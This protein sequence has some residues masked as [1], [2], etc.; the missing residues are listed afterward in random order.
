MIFKV[1][2]YGRA[3]SATVK[4]KATARPLQRLC[5]AIAMVS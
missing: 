5:I 4:D 2:E 3:L 1:S